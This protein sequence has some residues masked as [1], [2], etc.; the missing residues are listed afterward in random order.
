MINLRKDFNWKSILKYSLMTS[1]FS[2]V[3]GIIFFSLLLNTTGVTGL[4]TIVGYE[5]YVGFMPYSFFI[6][7]AI[8]SVL[9]T[10]NLED[11][12]D[13][14]FVGFLSGLI[15]GLLEY[16]LLHFVYGEFGWLLFTNYIGDQTIFLIAFGVIMAYVGN[17]YMKGKFKLPF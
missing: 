14:L 3:L 12:N 10:S 1:V 7:L 15:V 6:S 16:H 17:V 2:L 5:V 13:A 8:S 11:M 4:H 9:I